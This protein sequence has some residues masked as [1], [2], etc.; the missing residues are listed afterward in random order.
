[1]CQKIWPIYFGTYIFGTGFILGTYAKNFDTIDVAHMPRILAQLITHIFGT[2]CLTNIP[3][4]LAPRKLRTWRLSSL[5]NKL[6]GP[7][8]QQQ[9]VVIFSKKIQLPFQV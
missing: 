3:P 1:M 5:P 9:I 2:M 4:R 7:D 8:C 6:A